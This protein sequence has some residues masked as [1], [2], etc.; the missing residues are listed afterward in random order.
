[1]TFPNGPSHY[2]PL[3][4]HKK[5]ICQD[6]ENK[7]VPEIRPLGALLESVSK[8]THSGC[9]FYPAYCYYITKSRFV[10]IPRIKKSPRLSTR[11]SA[12]L[13]LK[14]TLAGA[15]FT[16]PTV[17]ISQK[18]KLSILK[19]RKCVCQK[20]KPLA[21]PR[22]LDKKRWLWYNNRN[23]AKGGLP[24]GNQFGDQINQNIAVFCDQIDNDIPVSCN[25]IR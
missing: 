16:L 13:A 4:Y 22:A 21:F 9:R 3:L 5:P 11:G 7:K 19:E 10:K 6:T 2:F 15:G 1:M 20:Q 18:I 12:S 8:E 25:Q 23:H 14:R 24:N 17:I